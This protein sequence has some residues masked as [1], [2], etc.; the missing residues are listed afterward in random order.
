[1]HLEEYL[2]TNKTYGLDKIST[3]N[4]KTADEF[5]FDIEDHKEK[6]P[7]CEKVFETRQALGNLQ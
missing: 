6:C 4:L 1:M 2:K 3:H 7:V 5:Q